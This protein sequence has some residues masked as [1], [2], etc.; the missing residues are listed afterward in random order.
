MKSLVFFII[1][2]IPLCVHAEHLQVGISL[3]APC[4]MKDANNYTGFDIDLW[5]CIAKDMGVAWTY[6]EIEF[7]KLLRNV[8]NKQFDIGIAG[9]SITSEREK[10]W[11]CTHSYLKAGIS[12]AKMNNSSIAIASI[13][14]IGIGL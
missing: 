3:L 11:D 14:A 6:K 7:S 1:L 8:R 2:I 13:I 4:V 10:Y 9:I 5:E 12:I